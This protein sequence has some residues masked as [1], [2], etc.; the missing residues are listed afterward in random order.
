MR[1][2][3]IGIFAA[4]F[5][6]I[7]ISFSA[8]AA[9]KPQAD[10][11]VAP[12]GNDAWSGHFI[13]P[14]AQGT[15]GPL[16]TLNGARDAVRRLKK[17]DRF[18]RSIRVQMREGIYHLDEPLV[19][20]PEDSGTKTL[21]ITYTA[22]PGETPRI[23][24]GVRVT[25]WK[26]SADG[27][28]WTAN[29]PWAKEAWYPRSLWINGRRATVARTP[30]EGEVLYSA[31]PGKPWKNRVEAR[32]DPTVCRSFKYYENQFDPTDWTLDNACAIYYHS[33]T[34]SRHGIEKI[35]PENRTVHFTNRSSWPI[36]YWGKK[37]RFYLENFPE[38]LDAP[39]EFYLDRK[40]GRLTYYPRAD[41]NFS[42][43]TEAILARTDVLVRLDGNPTDDQIIENVHFEGITFEHTDWVLTR[44]KM[45]DGQAAMF[46]KAATIWV[47]GA[48]NVTFE[49]CEV[50]HTGG[51]AIR[52]E[53][54]SKDC[55]VEQ[56]HL[57]DLG[58]GGVLLG[59]T[60]LSEDPRLQTERNTVSN[61]FIHGGGRVFQAGIGV[62]IG[63]SSHNK[64]LHNEICDLLYSGVS[65][66]WSWGYAPSS[67]H[68]NDISYNH[69]H[70]LGYGQLSDMGGIYSLGI[71][72]GTQMT[73]NRIHDVAGLIYGGW[74]LYTDEGSTDIVMENNIVYRVNDGAFHQHYGRDNIVRNNLLGFSAYSGQVIRS[75]EEK[76]N[77]FT[78][79]RNIIWCEPAP[80]LGKN[81]TNGNFVLKNNLYWRPGGESEIRFPGDKTL[82][83]WQADGHDQGSRIAD[84]EFKDVENF[85]FQLAPDSPAINLGF[86]PI[87]TSQIGLI[88]PNDWVA[89]PQKL[90]LPPVKLIGEE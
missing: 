1:K 90:N 43:Q 11:Y 71:S 80:P 63:K 87:D 4:L 65:V 40:T 86:K 6:L 34:A 69:I 59:E 31:G 70:H 26:K 20:T 13:E 7:V 47:R 54:G 89:M 45:M 9:E 61:C 35:D 74:G 81:W 85:N 75:R 72:P 12:N 51:Y 16:A 33:W 18:D 53:H 83:Q 46:L 39:G 30:N 5:I 64:V 88:G 78:I 15:D 25:G 67:A 50:A 49:R 58:A 76:H 82:A 3:T 79:E 27:P 57:H 68:H 73:Y 37:E 55:R 22:A 29:V 19:L 10:F 84:P 21:S 23:S 2:T 52:L 38:A 36:F 41:E 17:Q 56:C 8:S 32:K 60:G 24:G 66:G 77:S 42:P 14:N 62:W 28:T 44:D 48:S